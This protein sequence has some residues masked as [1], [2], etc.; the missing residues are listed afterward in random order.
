[1]VYNPGIIRK[2]DNLGRIVIPKEI[3][4]RHEIDDGDFVTI[5]DGA[6]HII[7]K[8]YRSGCIFCGSEEDITEYRKLYVCRSCRMTLNK[9]L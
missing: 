9:G 3:R 7:I 6:S 8:K 5:C 4:K 1:M 2:L